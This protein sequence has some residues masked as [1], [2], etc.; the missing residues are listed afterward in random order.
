M[1][2]KKKNEKDVLVVRDEKTGEISGE[3]GRNQRSSR[4]GQQG[5]SED[6]SGKG[7]TLAGL[8]ALRP[9]RG[10]GGQL[11][12]EL[13]PPVQGADTLR[14]LP[15]GGGH[16]GCGTAG[17]Q[18]FAERPCGKRGNACGAQGGHFGIP[19]AGGNG[20]CKTRKRQ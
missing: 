6:G 5:L 8:P 12:Q 14:L 20:E 11:L 13:L 10:H 7:G 17:H 18:G 3:D 9:T 1:E 4:A 16:G 19:E 2:Q 15:G